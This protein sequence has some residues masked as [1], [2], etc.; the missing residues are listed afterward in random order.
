MNYDDYDI[1][2]DKYLNDELSPD[3]RKQFE[4][5]LKTDQTLRDI[6]KL[7]KDVDFVIQNKELL[8]SRQMLE[9]IRGKR[10]LHTSTLYLFFYKHP[11]LLVAASV[12]IIIG[13]MFLILI[14]VKQPLKPET[15]FEGYYMPFEMVN[16][17]RITSDIG[18]KDDF[19][20][21]LNF[22]KEGKYK[23]AEEKI[24]KI[25][26]SYLVSENSSIVFLYGLINIE[27][28]KIGKAEQY[29]LML[30]SGDN[31]YY[32]HAQWYLALI[33]LKDGRVEDAKVILFK[34]IDDRTYYITKAYEVLRRL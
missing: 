17:I 1:L 2:T 4:E 22:Y 10:N 34:I 3:E 7:H 26:E 27:T 32:Q 31:R 24:G 15:I 29:F 6:I 12:L 16:N 25:P 8:K 14:S 23:K 30:K 19:Y 13:I 11:V 21:A 33:Y 5:K 9:K 18:Y 28:G 20:E